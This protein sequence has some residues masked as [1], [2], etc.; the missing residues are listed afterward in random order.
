[1]HVP[2]FFPSSS[3]PSLLPLFLVKSRGRGCTCA[4]SFYA[5]YGFYCPCSPQK[6]SCHAL[7]SVEPHMLS[8]KG[9]FDGPV[10]SQVPCWSGR[11]MCIDIVHVI[12]INSGLFQRSTCITIE[13]LALERHHFLKKG[14]KPVRMAVRDTANY[15][16]Q[17]LQD[18]SEHGG[19]IFALVKVNASVLPANCLHASQNSSMHCSPI[20]GLVKPR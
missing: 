2:S 16:L 13:T 12:Y 15:C 6:V 8:R 11:S 10:F 4:D 5:S 17:P 3:P 18:I 14:K 7:C 9:A 20:F 19:P 1:M